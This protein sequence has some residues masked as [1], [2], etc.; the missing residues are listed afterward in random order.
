VRPT[1]LALAFVLM[2]CAT[3]PLSARVCKYH[4][5]ADKEGQKVTMTARIDAI[6]PDEQPNQDGGVVGV[7]ESHRRHLQLG[8]WLSSADAESARLN[9]DCT[10]PIVSTPPHR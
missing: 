1:S 4:E 5:L 9:A 6:E 10:W 8:Y 2:T 7:A 3:A